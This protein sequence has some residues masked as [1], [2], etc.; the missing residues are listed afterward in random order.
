[1]IPALREAFNRNFLPETY[2]QLLKNLE[3]SR[4]HTHCVSCV[5][6]ALLFSQSPARPDGGIWP[7]PGSATGE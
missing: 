5:R 7:G 6:D 1:M 3:A 4:R 2:Q